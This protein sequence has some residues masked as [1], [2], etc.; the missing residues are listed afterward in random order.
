MIVAILYTKALGLQFDVGELHI[1]IVRKAL[2]KAEVYMAETAGELEERGIDPDIL[3][4]W[5]TGGGVFPQESIDFCV[6]SKNLKWL[7]G[8]SA[9]VEG[10]TYSAVCD[11]ENLRLTNA[12]GIH[13]IPISE[14]IIGF[15]LY[16]AREIGRMTKNQ[17]AGLWDRFIPAELYG[18]TL[19][20]LG[21]G[22]IA[23]AIA[24]RAKAFGMTVLGVKRTV[25]PL[26]NV[27]EVLP[28]SKMDEA[29]ARADYLVNLLP[30]TPD[31]LG[32]MDARRFAMMKSDAFFINAGRGTTVDT[33]ALVDALRSGKLSGAALDTMNPEPLPANHPFWKMENVIISPHISAETPRYM[34][35]AFEVFAENVPYYLNGEKM[36]TEIDLTKKY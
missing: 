35:R 11:R 17:R 13:G 29:I 36:S 10:V 21:M 15:M 24:V 12:K 31:T 22:S 18:H 14:H 20:I 1:N 3:I 28:E 25:V 6:R 5:V 34:E 8:L 32:T 26:E 23:S 27:A 2:P 9:G 33:E 19:T 7:H 4:T 30:A 16:H